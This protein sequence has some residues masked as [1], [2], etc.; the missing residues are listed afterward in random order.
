MISILFKLNYQNRKGEM[1]IWDVRTVAEDV[2]W[3]YI[4]LAAG[5]SDMAICFSIP[6]KGMFLISEVLSA[7]KRGL[8][9]LASADIQNWAPLN[10]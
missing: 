5:P 2:D 4:R 6:L 8:C 1:D 10:R 7:S 9:S 3:I